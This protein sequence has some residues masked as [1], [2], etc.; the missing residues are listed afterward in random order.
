ML[1][2]SCRIFFGFIITLT[3]L[4]N[5]CIYLDIQ[6]STGSCDDEQFQ[7]WFEK[8]QQLNKNIARVCRKYGESIKIPDLQIDN[9]KQ[10]R[11]FLHYDKMV[12]CPISKVLIIIIKIRL[13]KMYGSASFSLFRQHLPLGLENSID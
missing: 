10:K 3:I 7:C 6:I 12:Y 8:K 5:A 1:T 2:D 4:L 9:E 13:R 11:E